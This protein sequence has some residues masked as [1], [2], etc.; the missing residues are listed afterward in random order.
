MEI[1]GYKLGREVQAGQVC[2]TYNALDVEHGK[3]VVIKVFNKALSSSPAFQDHF[4]EVTGPLVDQPLS[5]NVEYLDAIVTDDACVIVTNYCPCGTLQQEDF[6]EL[7]ED[8]VLEIGVQLASSLSRL[9]SLGIVHGGVELSS[10]SFPDRGEV[11]LG[12]VAPQRTMPSNDAPLLVSQSLQDAACLAPEAGTGLTLSSD[13]FSLG[14]VLYELLLGRKPFDTDTMAEMEQQKKAGQFLPLTGELAHLNPLFD[15][16]LSPDPR[17]RIASDEHFVSVLN[18]CR[19]GSTEGG[20]TAPGKPADTAPANITAPP[21]AVAS[22]RQTGRRPLLFAAVPAVV[23]A[24]AVVFFMVSGKQEA[25]QPVSD[26][27]PSPVITEK[28]APIAKVLPPTQQSKEQI[29]ANGLFASARAL[30]QKGDYQAAL[31]AIDRS[32]KIETDNEAARNLKNEIEQEL[33]TRSSVAPA[34]ETDQRVANSAPD[35]DETERKARELAANRRAEQER[36]KQR[37]IAELAEQQRL[38][39]ARIA[40][41]EEAE[42]L[43]AQQ[44]EIAARNAEISQRLTTAEQQLTKRP[45]SWSALEMAESEY[46]VLVRIADD[47]SRVSGLYWRIVDSHI[48]L[49]DWQKNAAQLSESMETTNRGLALDGENKELL[50]LRNEIAN[51]IKESEEEKDEIPII[52]TF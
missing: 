47:D 30:V 44:L 46:R 43:A 20:Y 5:N 26:E 13:F 37:R 41:E 32:L 22:E 9:H 49:A 12:S 50:A 52:G 39:R 28:P 31:Q 4:R 1:P 25:P 6:P 33:K 10:I 16:L 7:S 36:A 34:D 19:M 23:V 2:T 51:A 45:L 18:T 3:T 35:A 8:K 42:R 21:V 15:G 48:A 24:A 38:E 40:R 29:E 14:V 27:E 17:S 11:V